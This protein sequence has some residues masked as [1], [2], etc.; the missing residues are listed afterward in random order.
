MSTTF[1]ARNAHAYQQFMGR[2]SRR[3]ARKFIAFAGLADG[4][5]IRV[6][7]KNV[8]TVTNAVYTPN[9]RAVDAVWSMPA[10]GSRAPMA[11][12]TSGQRD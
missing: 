1:H 8:F 10:A 2:W 5:R 9:W 11:G 3:L 12:S 7:D 6:H 4:E